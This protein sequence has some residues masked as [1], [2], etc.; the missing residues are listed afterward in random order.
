[1]ADWIY[2]LPIETLAI[3]VAVIV[4]GYCWIGGLLM[5]PLLRPFVRARHSGND[6]IGHVLSSFGVFYGLQLGLI[7]V[8]AY[9]NQLPP[10]LR[11]V[12]DCYGCFD[13]LSFLIHPRV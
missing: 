13:T 11:V 7:A 10:A 12:V 4:V 3:W 2:S 1:M 9:H 5:R 6:I 8:A